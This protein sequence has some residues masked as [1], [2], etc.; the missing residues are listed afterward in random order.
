VEL[1]APVKIGN[2]ASIGAG[3]TVTK[4][5]PDGALAISRVPQKNIKGWDKKAKLHR[6]KMK[7]EKS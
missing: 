3:A 5:V 1:V 4:D 6:A 7:K 2:D